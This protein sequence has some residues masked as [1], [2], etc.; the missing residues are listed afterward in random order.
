M[1]L[2]AKPLDADA[3]SKCFFRFLG[4]VLK[5]LFFPYIRINCRTM[6][7]TCFI[8]LGGLPKTQWHGKLP[9]WSHA[10]LNVSHSLAEIGMVCI[11]KVLPLTS[12]SNVEIIFTERSSMTIRP[13]CYG[14]QRLLLCTSKLH[15]ACARQYAYSPKH[16][17]SPKLFNTSYLYQYLFAN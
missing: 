9:K 7:I 11:C 16:R 6:D 12:W 1:S 14:H 17:H 4:V 5:S 15:K 10:S 2:V 13:F 8:L 3:A